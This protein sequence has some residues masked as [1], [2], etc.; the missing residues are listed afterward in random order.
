[1]KTRPERKRAP[2]PTHE[3]ADPGIKA[4][5]RSPCVPDSPCGESHRPLGPLRDAVRRAGRSADSAPRSHDP[6][7]RIHSKRS[8]TLRLGTGSGPDPVSRRGPADARSPNQMP[9]TFSYPIY[10]SPETWPVTAGLCA[11][12]VPSPGS[13]ALSPRGP[14]RCPSSLDAASHP[15]DLGALGPVPTCYKKQC[16]AALL[17]LPRIFRRLTS[18]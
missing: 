10:R 5:L 11:T 12:P 15:R 16:A 3:N 7:W 18:P 6:A 8:S 1:L 9:G 4:L 17:R 2:R 13:G 14:S